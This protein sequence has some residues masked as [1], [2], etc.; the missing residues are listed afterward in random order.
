MSDLA[1]Y[2]PTRRQPASSRLARSDRGSAWTVGVSSMVVTAA[3]EVSGVNRAVRS[4][5]CTDVPTCID[6]AAAGGRR[7]WRRTLWPRARV[8]VVHLC[9]RLSA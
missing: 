2:G 9:G 6:A 3:G 5:D 7:G 4:V 8:P 1:A